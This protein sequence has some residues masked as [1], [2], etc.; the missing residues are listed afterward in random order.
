M[1]VN[2]VIPTSAGLQQAVA[3]LKSA[4]E[5]QQVVLQLIQQVTGGGNVT[6]TRGNA[7]NLVV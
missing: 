4:V 1:D 3:A 6:A 5:Q 2:S 7:L